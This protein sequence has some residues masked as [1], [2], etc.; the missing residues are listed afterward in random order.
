LELIIKVWRFGFYVFL[1]NLA[2]LAEK[3]EKNKKKK[4][5]HGD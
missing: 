4:T 2:N 5:T 1:G 3:E